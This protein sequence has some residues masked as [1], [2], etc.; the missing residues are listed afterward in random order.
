[1]VVTLAHGKRNPAQ[2]RRVKCPAYGHKCE[3]C[4][5]DHHVETMCRSKDKPL[6]RQPRNHPQ[7]PAVHE[8]ALF[9]SFC[10]LFDNPFMN[11]RLHLE[12]TTPTE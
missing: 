11:S 6:R 9:D 12:V 7:K 1:M 8:D 4:Q 10:T 2:I 3:L 5:R